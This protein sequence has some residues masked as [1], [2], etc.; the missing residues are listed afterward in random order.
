MLVRRQTI[1]RDSISFTLVHRLLAFAAWF[2]CFIPYDFGP[3]NHRFAPKSQV[4]SWLGLC[5]TAAGL[6]FAI[7]A[8]LYLGG[9][10]SSAVTIKQDH[11]L[12]RSGP[13]ALA[14]HPI[15]S[16]FILGLFGTALVQAQWRSLVG[17]GLLFCAFWIKSG[18]EETFML[19]RFGDEYVQYRQ[20]V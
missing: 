14:R 7:E 8:R 18:R 12:V 3:L 11:T 4:L 5:L 17:V 9:N 13:Y 19:E 6:A 2:F 16:G 10:W 20:Q 1:R 15:Y